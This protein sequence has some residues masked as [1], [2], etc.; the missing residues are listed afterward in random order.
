M[1]SYV[2]TAGTSKQG[3]FHRGSLDKGFIREMSSSGRISLARNLP[4]EEPSLDI[5]PLTKESHSWPD[6]NY[7]KR[8]PK[9]ARNVES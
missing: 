5:W 7:K 9:R 6:N 2:V 8:I 4:L 1:R 3:L